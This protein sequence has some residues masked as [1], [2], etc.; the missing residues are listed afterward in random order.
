MRKIHK[1]SIPIDTGTIHIPWDYQ[2]LK[3]AGQRENIC[4]WAVVETDAASSPMSFAIVPTGVEPPTPQKGHYLDTVFL[5]N[6]ALVF[7]VYMLREE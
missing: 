5:N 2:I 6:G 4:L 3:V 7:H 1:Y